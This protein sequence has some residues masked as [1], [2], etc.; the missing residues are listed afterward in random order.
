MFLTTDLEGTVEP[1]GCTTD[2][3]G[4][5]SRTAEIIHRARQSKTPVLH[6]DGGSTLYSLEPIPP[7][8][9]AQEDLKADL[10][11]ATF[12]DVLRTDA[13]G[14]GP[15]DLVRGTAKVRPP[16]LAGNVSGDLPL[17]PPQLLETSAG[18]IGVF[19]VVG[20]QALKSSSVK[21]TDPVPVANAAA[22]DLKKRGAQAVFGLFYMTRNELQSILPQISGVDFA[23][24]GQTVQS[25]PLQ[26]RYE[27]VQVGSTWIIEPVDRGQVLARLDLS[28][29]GPGAWSDA[30]GEGRAR[31]EIPALDQRIKMLEADL[32][33]FAA[34]PTADKNFIASKQKE[35]ADVRAEKARLEKTPLMVPKS[36]S[37]FTL[38]Q[39]EIKKR[40][41]CLTEVKQKKQALDQAIGKAN[42]A[43]AAG[44]KPLPVPPG[45]SG[46]VGAAECDACHADAVEFWKKTK[47]AGAWETLVHDKK[48]F[49]LDC[50]SCHVTG[51]GEPGGSSLADNEK[52]RDVQCEVCHGPG[53][54]HVAAAGEEKTKTVVRT[55]AVK[56]CLEC[57]NE[58]HSDTFQF[59]AYLRD[60]TGPGHGQEFREKLGAG[61]TGAQLRGAG[62]K[63]AGAEVGKGCDK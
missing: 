5:L 38:T 12:K 10:I 37:W 23:I 27:P 28:F 42:L 59:E 33:Q 46:Y 6:F 56:R 63:K 58:K 35:L 49:N 60:V 32:Q 29:E 41:P 15:H 47:H 24:V 25:T 19:G 13:V 57:H 7:S 44:Q 45:K 18:K 16:R 8:M 61:A 3:M 48:E 36:G 39:I 1:C 54:R 55:P 22:A 17:A 50:T 52:L 9:V 62:L 43:A 30:I 20:T 4:D 21:V 31:I 11:V 40:L 26:I 51:W 53:S 34:D 2:P 14:L